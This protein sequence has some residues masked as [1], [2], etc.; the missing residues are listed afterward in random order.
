MKGDSKRT[1]RVLNI[2]KYSKTLSSYGRGPDRGPTC[3]GPCATSATWSS[4]LFDA[5]RGCDVGRR[6]WAIRESLAMKI[7]GV[8]R[9]ESFSVRGIVP[10]VWR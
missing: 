4:G 9:G 6:S 1:K 10:T 5:M 7:E 8:T 3:E 2:P